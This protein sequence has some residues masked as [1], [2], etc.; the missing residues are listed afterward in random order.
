M[1]DALSGALLDVSIVVPVLDERESVA[2]LVEEIVAAMETVPGLTYEVVFVDDGSRDAT[3]EE[4]VRVGKELPVVRGQ[5]LRRNFGKAAALSVGVWVARGRL[6]VT[7][8]GDRQDDPAEIPRLLEMLGSGTDL[9]SGWKKDRH[10]PLGKRAPSKFFN[11]VTAKVAGLDLHDFNC[12]FK[13]G[14]REVYLHVPLY[15]EMHRYVPVFA[16]SLG[17]RVDELDVHHRP[18]TT[19]RSKYG[20]ERFTRGAADL[21]TVVV[22]A[23]FGRRPGHFFGGL[24][25]ALMMIGL[26]VLAYL[27]GVWVF[28][29]QAIGTRPLLS[30]G[31]LLV[32]LGGQLIVLGVLA[33]LI[34]NRTNPRLDPAIAVLEATD[35][36]VDP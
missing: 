31:V 10:D 33:E 14:L 25:L 3:W 17:Y 21:A 20:L 29:D 13:A 34:L 6:L 2:P 26:V 28:T 1:S 19:G 11:L 24:G 8:D 36:E 22:L 23:R 7:M 9:V 4:I 27:T 32:V 5:R 15:G 12:G 16:H 35:G 30:L 18:R